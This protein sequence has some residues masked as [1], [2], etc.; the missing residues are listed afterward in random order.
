[1]KKH[2]VWK[3]LKMSHLFSIYTLQAIHSD[4]LFSIIWIFAH[5]IFSLLDLD[6][7]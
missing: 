6:F 7:S 2:I 5:K 4:F 3:S 1:M